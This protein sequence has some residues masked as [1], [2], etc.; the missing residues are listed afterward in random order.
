MLLW[1]NM[2]INTISFFLFINSFVPWEIRNC[3]RFQSTFFEM[4]GL[5]ISLRFSDTFLL[6]PIWYRINPH[7]LR[8]T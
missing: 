5:S 4:W 2:A 3:I 7:I 1:F 8:E 6:K